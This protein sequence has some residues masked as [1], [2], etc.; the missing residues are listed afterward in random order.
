MNYAISLNKYTFPVGVP[1]KDVDILNAECKTKK[2][3]N[4][5]YINI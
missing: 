5:N 4:T 2:R 3:Q 1:L